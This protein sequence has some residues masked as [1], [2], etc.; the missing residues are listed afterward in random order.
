[1]LL[2]DDL[3]KEVWSIAAVERERGWRGWAGRGLVEQRLILRVLDP[4]ESRL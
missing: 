3:G 1:V 2:T 4:V